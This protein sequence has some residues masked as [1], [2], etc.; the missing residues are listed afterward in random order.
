[1]TPDVQM[2][3]SSER[4][5]S[6]WGRLRLKTCT[7]TTLTGVE[8]MQGTRCFGRSAQ[9]S[10]LPFPRDLLIPRFLLISRFRS[11]PA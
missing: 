2:S 10:V 3:E 4:S 6:Q 9:T 7:L 8:G 5:S 11:V 1:M